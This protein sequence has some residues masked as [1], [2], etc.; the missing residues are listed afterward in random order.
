M[1][2]RATC[3]R[4]FH[5]V[6]II[7]RHSTKCSRSIEIKQFS[8]DVTKEIDQ[9]NQVK[10]IRNDGQPT[11][12]NNR[13]VNK[14]DPRLHSFRPK[15]VS[16]SET[17]ILLFPGQGSQ[18]VG[19]CKQLQ[20]NAI[21]QALFRKANQILGYDL[22][23]VCLKGPANELEQTVHCQPA[24][25]VASLAGMLTPTQLSLMKLLIFSI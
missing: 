5:S 8:N 3:N 23:D 19:M 17:S 1:L 10:E 21:V 14:K 20:S 6:E 16:P 9:S 24:I 2:Q 18:Y 11:E 7:A 25:F 22:L 12:S 13:Y 15:S 4:L